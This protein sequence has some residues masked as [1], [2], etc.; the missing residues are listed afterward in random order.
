[1]AEITR[2]LVIGGTGFIGHHLL[3]VAV[4]KKWLVSSLSL[5]PPKSQRFVKGVE[6]LQVDLLKQAELEEFFHERE[7]E[8]V[9]NLGGYINHT[10]F[11]SGGR[12]LIEE[13][14][15]ADL[16]RAQGMQPRHRVLLSGPPGNGKTSVAEA[17]ASVESARSIVGEHTLKGSQIIYP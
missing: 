11:R 8:Y 6:Y 10:L 12:Q 2:L 3:N 14:R 4:D 17:I 7:F 1:M 16:L 5:H 15:R 13:Q 9:V